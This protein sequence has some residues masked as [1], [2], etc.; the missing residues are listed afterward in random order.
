MFITS[1][2]VRF[3]N[4]LSFYRCGSI[5]RYLIREN[6][7]SCYWLFPTIS[8]VRER[9]REP[10]SLLWSECAKVIRTLFTD[11]VVLLVAYL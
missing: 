4:V 3:S 8:G 10:C 5:K 9:S 2:S 1:R 11:F 6:G 7:H